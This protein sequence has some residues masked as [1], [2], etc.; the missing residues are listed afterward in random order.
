MA[1]T[2]FVVVSNMFNPEEETERNW[3]LDLA[4]DVKGE[5][6]GKYG[7]LKRIKVDKM[8]AVGLLL[9]MDEIWLMRSRAKYTWSL[10]SSDLQNMLSRDSMGVSLGEGNCKR[11]LSLRRCLK[12]T[13][14]G[15]VCVPNLR[16]FL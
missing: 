9:L 15:C 2:V 6:E 3:D 11:H 1:P 10:M 14:N 13:S 4:E 5:I 8:S 12:R 7:K 16:C